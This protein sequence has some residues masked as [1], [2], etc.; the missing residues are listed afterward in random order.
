MEIHPLLFDT[1]IH[2]HN[3]PT[4]TYIYIYI[5]IYIS[6]AIIT[7]SKRNSGTR[8]NNNWLRNKD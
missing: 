8:S 3:T 6:I 1:H 4:H 2:T 7:T 5:Y